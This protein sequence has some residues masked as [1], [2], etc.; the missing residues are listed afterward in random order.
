MNDVR[1]EL[2][3]IF[4]QLPA[5]KAS[6][7]KN[8]T[9]MVKETNVC[10][11]SPELPNSTF[12]KALM[13]TPTSDAA[14]QTDLINDPTQAES[15]LHTAL[16]TENNADSVDDE[17]DLYAW[18]H[19]GFTLRLSSAVAAQIGM[20]CV[21]SE[22]A[23][24]P[25]PVVK[26]QANN[27]V[28]VTPASQAIEDEKITVAWGT[29]GHTMR[30][31]KAAAAKLGMKVTVPCTASTTVPSEE[32]FSTPVRSS[33]TVMKSPLKT[34]LSG[35]FT[36]GPKPTASSP[37]DTVISARSPS[38]TPSNPVQKKTPTVRYSTF[39]AASIMLKLANNGVTPPPST[40]RVER[41]KNFD[42]LSLA[43]MVSMPLCELYPEFYGPDNQ[44]W[45]KYRD[46]PIK[47]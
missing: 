21:V 17:K 7:T 4:A 14:V 19:T 8:A 3:T 23:P 24:I 2:H 16:P 42:E 13:L 26:Q 45:P 32:G 20:R 12:K 1:D 15:P 40:A 6:P 5:S 36:V 28:A 35:A 25:E 31:S 47:H 11:D 18:G 33:N 10:V 9:K 27:L 29:R 39:D 34:P 37:T 44:L 41:K 46:L 22:G 43:E 38:V 30:L